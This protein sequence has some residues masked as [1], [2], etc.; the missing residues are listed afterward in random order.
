[1]QKIGAYLLERRDGMD[2]AAARTAEANSIRQVIS[3]WLQSKGATP[4]AASGQYRPEDGSQGTILRE[5]AEDGSRSW[6]MVRLDEVNQDGR[7]FS[8]TI[9]VTS[10]DDRVAVYATLEAGSDT[11]RIT[12]IQIDPR[13]PRV[14]RTL[15]DKPGRWYH[16]SSG[17]RTLTKAIGFEQGE[18]VAHEIASP[19]RSIPLL[20]VTADQEGVALPGLDDR[21]GYDVAGLAN[22]VWLDSDATWALTDHLGTSF[23]CYAGAVRLYWPRFS[24]KDDPFRHP[25]WTA[26]RLRSTDADPNESRDIFRK[27]MRNLLMRAA[28]LSVARPFEI[29]E[30][31]NAASRRAF[32]EMQARASSVEDFRRLADSYA[33]DNDCLR[34]ENATLQERTRELEAQIAD[35]EGQRAALLARIENAELQLRYQ[36]AAGHEIAPDAVEDTK[37]E[38]APPAPGEVRFYK[39]H[40]SAPGHD[41]MT[42]VNDCGCNN[43]EAAFKADK[44]KKGILRLEDKTEFKSI[45]HCASCDGGGV[46]KVRW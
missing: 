31:R 29:D 1:M 24:S 28:A 20:I 35:F 15:L 9:S 22:V 40:Y 32:T 16:G 18:V 27:Q 25:L 19:D 13:C 38:V 36:N 11:S 7:R 34:V 17:L 41:I 6:S 12:P 3:D 23:S 43:W 45:Q 42:R 4:D 37:E 2:G 26:P 8:A 10:A 14:I 44:A 39:K 21:L 5:Q 46:W 30:I 33:A